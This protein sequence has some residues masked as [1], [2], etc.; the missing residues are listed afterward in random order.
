[1]DPEKR[2]QA[3]FE[4]QDYERREFPI[5]YI[6]QIGQIV[7]VSK[8]LRDWPVRSDERFYFYRND[9]AK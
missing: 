8:K 1:M 6:A 9:V 4:Q 7:G 3:F 2:R 5:V